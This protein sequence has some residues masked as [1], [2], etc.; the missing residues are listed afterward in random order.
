MEL[1]YVMVYI[2]VMFSALLVVIVLYNSGNLS[3]NERVKEFAT[4]KVMGFQSKRIRRLI[5]MQN[6]CL[7]VIGVL[8]GA[9]FGRMVLQSM[10]DSNGDSFDYQAVISLPYYILAGAFVLIV[11]CLVSFMF[12]K[13]IKKLDMVEVLKGME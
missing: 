5:S 7:S 2:M 13:R 6:L 1:M 4:L 9:Q 10:F 8:V 12:S 11:S 3:F